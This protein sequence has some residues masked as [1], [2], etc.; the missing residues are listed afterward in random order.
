MYGPGSYPGGWPPYPPHQGVIYVP[1]PIPGKGGGKGS[2]KGFKTNGPMDILT[3]IQKTK[4]DLEKLEKLFK[5]EEKK[6]D[7]KDDNKQRTFTL[8]ETVGLNFI[9]MLPTTLILY[10]LLKAFAKVGGL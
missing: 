4:D 6:D 9:F 10:V 5:K 7:K 8:L 3:N 2:R 1:M